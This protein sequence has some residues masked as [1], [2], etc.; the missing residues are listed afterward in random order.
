[1]GL[2]L[3]SG[4]YE[5]TA[6]GGFSTV[7]GNSELIQRIGMKLRARRGS[8][9]PLPGFG[10]RLY[11]L[12]QVKPNE[13]EIAA[14]QYILEALSDESGLSLDELK[15]D[16]TSEGEIDIF[17]LFHRDGEHISVNTKIGGDY[18]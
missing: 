4:K 16:C 8:F 3:E 11:L 14:R 7:S 1:M 10:S 15:L 17:M 2:K 13:R 12:S 18:F 9:F 6:R 5:P